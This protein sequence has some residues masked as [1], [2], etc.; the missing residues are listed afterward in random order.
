MKILIIWFYGKVEIKNK[1]KSWL[2][3]NKKKKNWIELKKMIKIGNNTYIKLGFERKQNI[4]I[5]YSNI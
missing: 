4:N 5:W 1:E 3:S 2:T